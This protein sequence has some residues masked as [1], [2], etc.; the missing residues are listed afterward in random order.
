MTPQSWFERQSVELGPALIGATLVVRGCALRITE[1][2]AYSPEDPASH[3]FPGPTKRNAAMFGPAGH[4]YVYRSYGIHWCL[5]VTS[6]NGHGVLLR[7]GEPLDGLALMAERRGT[8]DP[9]NIATGPGKLAQALGI[10]DG[11]YGRAFATLEFHI[12]PG[13]EVEIL[14]GPRIGISK[15]QDWPRRFGLK[16]SKFLSKPFP[17][18]C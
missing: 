4:A 2:E 9:R 13:S 6:G 16:G 15:A 10:T 11:D 8:K 14:A 17:F 3:T 18:S 1:T 12:L 5:N 7:A